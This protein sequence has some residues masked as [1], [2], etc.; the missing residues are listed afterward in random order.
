[1]AQSE[2]PSARLSNIPSPE[3]SDIFFVGKDSHGHW[4][5]QD[6]RHRRCGIF[7]NEAAAL[8]FV[9]AENGYRAPAIVHVPEPLEVDLGR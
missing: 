4:V 2:P 5:A 7:V 3:T 8:R 6:L 1:M 9:R